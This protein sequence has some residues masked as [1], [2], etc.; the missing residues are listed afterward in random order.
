MVLLSAALG[1]TL[2]VFAVN[3]MENPALPNEMVLYLPLKDAF[4]EH[5]NTGG[6]FGLHE[7]AL[8]LRDVVNALDRAAMDTRVKGFVMKLEGAVPSLAHNE[9]LRTAI[10]RFRT[11]GKFAF[12]YAPAYESLGAYYL[13]TAFDQIWLQPM[14]IVSVPGINMEMPYARTVLDKIG[15]EPQFFARKEYKNFFESLT[16]SEMSLETR[17]VMTALASDISSHL[18]KEIAIAR[19]MTDQEV[20][21]RID[22]GL[23]TDDEALA[24]GLID[25]LDYSDNL[26]AEIKEQVTGNPDSDDKIFATMN[27]YIKQMKK[28][29]KLTSDMAVSKKPKVA[30]IYAAGNIIQRDEKGALAAA[31]NIIPVIR[32]AADDDKISVIVLRI[33][34]PGGD[35]VAAEAIRRALVKA[36]ENGKKIVVS[37]GAAAASGGYWIAADADYIYALPTTFTGSIG[38]TGGKVSLKS[39]WEN[40]GIEWDR[41]QVGENAGL[42]SL[43]HPY[44]PSEAARMNAMMD[45]VYNKFIALVANGRGMTLEQTDKIAGGRVWTGA[46]AVDA[47]LVDALGGLDAALDYAAILAGVKNRS[48]LDV[49]MMQEPKTTFEKLVELLETQTMMSGFFHSNQALFETVAAGLRSV[50]SSGYEG[51]LVR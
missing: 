8:V 9:E 35:P 12:I 17:E 27:I 36:K 22:K 25:R 34:S 47:G 48:D 5:E 26:S 7:K 2:S 10:M 18:F 19:N 16:S 15:I 13:A 50:T 37:M 31:E 49:L 44:S 42:W 11:S 3:K 43:N 33:D 39:M 4:V 6:A 14:G 38:V 40:I 1:T 46:Q 28:E 51:F 41:V 24:T 45:N 32:E 23:L 21:A 30:L 29:K 20:R